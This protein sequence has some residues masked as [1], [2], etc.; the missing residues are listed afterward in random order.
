MKSNTRKHLLGGLAALSASLLVITTVGYQLADTFRTAVDGA[1]GTQSYITNTED[2][3]YVSDYDSNDELAEA[4]REYAVRQGQEGTVIMK[5]D[6]DALPLSTS[7]EIALFGVAAYNNY[8]S[9]AST[10]RITLRQ[11]LTDAGFTVNE[12]VASATENTGITPN[13]SAGAYDSSGYQIREAN[14]NTYT[15]IRT[16][17]N[18]LSSG[19]V[20]IVVFMRPG[21]EGSTW[22]P[23]VARDTAGNTLDQNPLAFSPDELAVVALAKE[24]CDKVIVMLNTYSPMEIEPLVEGEYEVDGIVYAGVPS[25]YQFEGIVDVLEGAVNS[26]GALADTFAVSTTSSPSMMNFGGD[27]WS[28]Y[29]VVATEAGEDWRYDTAMDNE[30]VTGSFGGSG[31]AGA[32]YIVEA[33]GIYT[34][35]NYY[36]TRYYDSIVNP[37]YNAS[38]ATANDAVSGG[39]DYSNE[40]TYSF[41]YGL[42]YIPYTQRIT[43]VT[44]EDRASGNI[45]ATIEVTNNGDQDGLFLT[46]LYVSQPYTEYDRENLVEKSAIM[47]LNSAKVEVAAG[48]TETVTI[49]IPTKYLAS[50]DYTEAKTYILDGGRY[51]FTAAAGAHAAVN[52]VLAAQGYSTEDGMDEEGDLNA[53]VTW[54]NAGTETQPDTTTYSISAETGAVI[55]NQA[56][57]ADINYYL[58]ESSQVTYLSRQNW[59][60]TY[61]VNYNEINNGEG[62]SLVNDAKDSATSDE[63]INELRNNQY[64]IKDDEPVENLDGVLPEGFEIT[65]NSDGSY[66]GTW[67]LI[68][69]AMAADFNDSRWND[70]IQSISADQAI[71]AVA[72]GGSQSDTLDNLY[73]PIV[74]QNDGPTGFT[75]GSITLSDGS[76]FATNV[77]SQSLMGSSFNPDLAY[78]WGVLLGNTG[79]ML[80]RYVIWAGGL[81]YHRNPYNARNIE[82]LS[83]D[84]M[85][86]NVLGAGLVRGSLEKGIIVGP[87]H[88]GFNDQEYH[89]SGLGVYL[90]EQKLRQTDLRG[91]EGAIADEDA[92]GMMIA[93]NRIGAINASHHVGMNMGIFRGEW[94]FLGLSTTDMMNN[95]NYFNPESCIM[96]GITMMADF[97]G[98]NSTI[99][100]NNG[101]DS[102]WS[103]LSVA[104]V[105]NDNTLVEQARLCMKY[106]LYAFANSA[107]LNIS[108]TA[109]TPWWDTTLQA[110]N[111]AFI[112]TTCLLGVGWLAAEI[113]PL[114]SKKK[115]EA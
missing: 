79:L 89:R 24:T 16:A 6:N 76:T 88:I 62:F 93:F 83:E 52:N 7:N 66:V 80:Q 74:G 114:V 43:D 2:A 61:P 111:I 102:T 14:P 69:A 49:T 72:H 82:Y 107:V 106:Q 51:Y 97:A 28:D 32:V 39:W 33:E 98:N 84:P 41:G 113:V 56:D 50:Y 15:T 96:A 48:Q 37:S 91:F 29:D 5:N 44:V 57:N 11:A 78:D 26:T 108:T 1:L 3:K 19:A 63:W 75:S 13:T 23:G 103:Y 27:T 65:Q 47:F 95:S 55:T 112:V 110:V 101:I 53:V 85:L 22:Y 104:A 46:Q 18:S 67:S 38:E 9:G 70:V 34:G 8:F 73:N 12:A 42:S 25:A 21:G 81:N 59:S 64:E 45:T 77:N 4:L 58:K 99:S 17:A 100:G 94:G 90:N 20:G 92:L 10:G 40:V 115:K 109:V 30:P 71:G 105:S 87:K 54:D 68:D 31:Y 35:Y 86:T 60:G 36:E